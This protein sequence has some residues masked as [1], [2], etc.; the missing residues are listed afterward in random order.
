MVKYLYLFLAGLMFAL[1]HFWFQVH[2]NKGMGITFAIFG[3]ILLLG[4]FVERFKSKK[5][6]RNTGA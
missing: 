2:G 1:A 3:I 6:D 5:A 4:F